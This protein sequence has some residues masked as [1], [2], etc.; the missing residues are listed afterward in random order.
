ME[1]IP[2][3]KTIIIEDNK[4]ISVSIS[5]TL[6][7]NEMATFQNDTTQNIDTSAELEEKGKSIF[8]KLVS[9][10]TKKYGNGYEYEQE[11][12]DEL[13]DH[14]EYVWALNDGVVYRITAL[15]GKNE[16]GDMIYS[17]IGAFYMN[18]DL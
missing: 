7:T 6:Q 4:I 2:M 8:N 11:P 5:V 18:E 15:W 1:E 13:R 9:S 12:Y 16:N 10:A 3:S 14:E 17:S